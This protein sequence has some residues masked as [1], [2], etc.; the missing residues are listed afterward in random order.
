VASRNGRSRFR[1]AAVNF[2]PTSA[3]LLP[4]FFSPY[5]HRLR[6]PLCDQRRRST[7][8]ILLTRRASSI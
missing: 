6:H 4:T 2:I 7:R 8:L 3:F 5:D 1:D